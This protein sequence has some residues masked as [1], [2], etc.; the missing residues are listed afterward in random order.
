MDYFR[1]IVLLAAIVGVIAGI[2]MTVAQ[3]LTTVPLILRA[4]FFEQAEETKAPVAY[5]H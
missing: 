4:E 1:N 5:N 3:Q 2:G